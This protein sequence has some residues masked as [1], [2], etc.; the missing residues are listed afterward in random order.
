M[1]GWSSCNDN[2]YA[3]KLDRN[4]NRLWTADAR[5]NLDGGTAGQWHPSVAVDGS[6]D[7]V[8]VWS[9]TRHGNLG[10][11]AQKLGES[12][13][14]LWADDVRVYMGGIHIRM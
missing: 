8:A 4:G 12:G 2:V 3:Q 6:G 1:G 13:G 14:R 10:I 7:A 9:D 11:Y 5:I